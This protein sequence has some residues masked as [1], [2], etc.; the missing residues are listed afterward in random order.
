MYYSQGTVSMVSGSAIV[1][2]TGTKFN[3]NINGVAPGQI[4]LIQSGKDNLLHMIQA[5]NSDTELVLADK[6]S[7]TLNNATYQIQITVPD[8][9]SDATR[10]L[11]AINSYIVQFLQNMDRWMSQSGVV[12][13]TLPNGQTVALQS[14][15]ALQ[16]AVDGKLD[17]TG[18]ALTGELSITRNKGR[19]LRMNAATESHANY[20]EMYGGDKIVGWLGFGEDN[21]S[22]L[23]IGNSKTRNYLH[24]S[25]ELK[26]NDRTVH[27]HGGPV[28]DA[29][30]DLNMFLNEGVYYFN[31][32]AV[33]ESFPEKWGGTLIVY[34]GPY[35]R[36][37]QVYQVYGTS[38][39][40]RRA[41]DHENKFLS[42]TKDWNTSNANF[43]NN[44]YLKKSSPI[45]QIHPDGTF[46]TN[47]ESEGATVSK[48][49][50]GHYQI[51]GILGYNA[52][53]AWGV[54]GGISSPKNNNGLELIYIDDRVE[55]DGSITIE[56]FHRQHSH[57]PE[58]F[59]N[60]RIKA[61][62]DGE[63]VYY[64]DGEPCD[65]P[66]GCR[67]DVRVQMPEDSVWNVGQKEAE[68]TTDI[69]QPKQME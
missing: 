13:V 55:K 37:Y 5:V 46:T 48:L 63:K 43:D 54:H 24:I 9:A 30:S 34:Q 4:M 61:L 67:L 68:I 35:R 50:T 59:Q 33:S 64:A 39:I 31:N 45:L 6:A 60:K 41:T 10:H 1:R 58:R 19:M 17:K 15:R 57:L 40:Y 49:G 23:T 52:D 66:E 26:F 51:D 8:S 53:G 56:T 27:V 65:I 21:D 69:D 44:G 32:N 20:L 38:A 36:C 29:K 12:D 2:G 14:I 47:D 16:A 25:D 11:V 7:V 28:I 22:K 42:W 62:V 3:A 18:G